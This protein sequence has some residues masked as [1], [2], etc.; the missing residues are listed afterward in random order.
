MRLVL[1]AN[2]V[3]GREQKSSLVWGSTLNAIIWVT[4]WCRELNY[5]IIERL[6]FELAIYATIRFL[7][8]LFDITMVI[9]KHH[10]FYLSHTAMLHPRPRAVCCLSAVRPV[11]ARAWPHV[12]LG[13]LRPRLV[14][15]A[16]VVAVADQ[17]TV[18]GAEG[19]F[20]DRQGS[21]ILVLLTKSL[22]LDKLFLAS[23][24]KT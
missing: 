4:T 23:L 17:C 9:Y 2:T 10:V 8:K 22:D 14:E 13:W 20:W 3:K 6:D 24:L 12:V 1:K 11:L 18:E 5:I 19:T 15:T 7:K 16:S 21:T